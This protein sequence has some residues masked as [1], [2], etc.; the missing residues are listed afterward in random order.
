VRLKDLGVGDEDWERRARV[1]S[2]CARLILT[3]RISSQSLSGRVRGRMVLVLGRSMACPSDQARLWDVI[4]GQGGPGMFAS[5]ASDK[6]GMRVL[7]PVRPR[8]LGV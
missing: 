3:G 5:F 8:A 6:I 2:R 4:I 1:V 7:L